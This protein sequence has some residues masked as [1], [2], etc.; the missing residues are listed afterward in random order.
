MS[1]TGIALIS[2][3]YNI[4]SDILNQRLI[5]GLARSPFL[6]S[7]RKKWISK[8]ERLPISPLL[9][10]QYYKKQKMSAK[11]YLCMFYRYEKASHCVNRDLLWYSLMQVRIHGKFIT[12]EK[13]IFYQTHCSIKINDNIQI[14]FPVSQGVKQRCKISRTLLAIYIND[15]ANDINFLS[16]GIQL[17]NSHVSLL[18]Y[19]DDIALIFRHLI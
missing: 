6:T 14:F 16:F 11:R 3:P 4:Y 8:K 19:A 13:S 15:L 10:K 12:A 2:V 7:G 1:F 17:N 5:Y 18:L 9:T